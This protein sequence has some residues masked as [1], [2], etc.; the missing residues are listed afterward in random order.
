[1]KNSTLKLV[2]GINN[3]EIDFYLNHFNTYENIFKFLEKEDA[4]H[5]IDFRDGDMSDYINYYHNYMLNVKYDKTILDEI[6]E[7][8]LWDVIKKGND[9][10]LILSDLTDLSD[11]FKS[12]DRETSPYDVA[13]RVLTEDYWEFFYDTTQDIYNDVIEELNEE[14]LNYLKQLI[15]RRLPEIEVDDDFPDLL[16]ELSDEGIVRVNQQNIDEIISDRETTDFILDTYLDDVMSDLTS[17]HNNAYNNAYESEYYDKVN[18]ELSTY[19]DMRN[20][21]WVKKGDKYDIL[22]KINDGVLYNILSDFVSEFKDDS[23]NNT[24]EY[25][26]YLLRIIIELM[27]YSDSYDKLY[28]NIYDYPDH[29][30]VVKNINEIFGDYL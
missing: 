28:F 11:L 26:S 25:H 1:M 4:L 6:V 18:D 16:V 29:S 24:I 12:Y 20:K 30:L 15:I 22:I 2:N 17:I 14:N 3:G 21:E 9:Y 10:Y 27:E 23:Y 8:D 5:L 19:F 13:S 7:K